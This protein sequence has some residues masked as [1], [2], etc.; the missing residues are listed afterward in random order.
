M[1][2]GPPGAQTPALRTTDTITKKGDFLV[3]V[4]VRRD[5]VQRHPPSRPHSPPPATTRPLLSVADTLPPGEGG[6]GGSRGR[7]KF[8][9]LKWASNFRP[10]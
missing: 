5:A 1:Y 6:V 3:A 8:V 7:K 2:G 9:S 10:L 4:V